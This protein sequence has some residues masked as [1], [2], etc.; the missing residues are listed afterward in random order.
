MVRDSRMTAADNPGLIRLYQRTTDARTVRLIGHETVINEIVLH[1]I[2]SD[3]RI[4]YFQGNMTIRMPQK[5]LLHER[6]KETVI[7]AFITCDLYGIL[8]I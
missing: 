2:I 3:V 1:Q 7:I 8:H 5:K 6:L 4:T